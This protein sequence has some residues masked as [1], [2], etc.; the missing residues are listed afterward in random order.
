MEENGG[1]IEEKHWIDV[2]KVMNEILTEDE[3]P[4]SIYVRLWWVHK[5]FLSLECVLFPSSVLPTSIEEAGRRFNL[6]F[7]IIT[8]SRNERSCGVFS[9][10]IL[11]PIHRLKRGHLLNSLSEWS[12]YY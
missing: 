12:H 3:A 10:F 6:T 5:I 1:N 8:D 7:G 2:W 9:V 11:I 4:P